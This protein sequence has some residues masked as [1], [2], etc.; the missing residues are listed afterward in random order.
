MSNLQNVTRIKV[1]YDALQELAGEV[2]FVGGAVVSLYA[3]R[4]AISVRPTDDVDIVVEIMSYSGFA[5]IEEKLREKGFA[6]DKESRVICRYKING[7][8]VDIMPTGEGILGFSNKWYA[9]AFANSYKFL[10]DDQY[11]IRLFQPAWFIASKLEAFKDRGGN[12]GR[13][14]SDF[15]DIVFILNNRNG[16]W[17][18]MRNAPGPLNEYLKE[19]FN[20]LLANQYIYEWIGTHLEF[21][22]QRRVNFIIGGLNQLLN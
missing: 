6:H 12:D 22:E 21:S 4:P 20:N 16:I 18:E 10:L 15:E 17:E 1:V 7:V 19:Q 3:D 14:S 2:V 5:T 13:M 8:I 9:E 11:H